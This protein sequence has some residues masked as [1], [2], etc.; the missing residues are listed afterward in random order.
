MLRNP[1]PLNAARVFFLATCLSVTLLFFP[2]PAHAL[3]PSIANTQDAMSSW[4]ADDGLPQNGIYA[5]AQTPDGYLWFA[6]EEGVARFD[7]V[8]F[9]TFLER[10]YVSA[11]LVSRDGSLWIASGRGLTRYKNFKMTFYPMKG[12]R[13]GMINSMSEGLD[14]SI[15]MASFLG[16]C[17]FAQGKFSIYGAGT[18]GSAPDWIWSTTVTRDGALWWGT[19][20]S[21]LKRLY[22]GSVTT[23]T[24]RDG[25]AD[26]IVFALR[27][28]RKGDLWIGTN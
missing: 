26:N 1:I 7:G 23:F 10:R 2:S 14:G 27:E 22:K 5:I 15:W 13:T 18:L 20:G 21:G 17:R 3:D 24:T 6:T 12:V 28:D 9:K 19:N 11:L 8:R 4:M 16:L 25:L